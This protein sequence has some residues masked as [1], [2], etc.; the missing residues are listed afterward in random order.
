MMKI[1]KR[2]VFASEHYNPL[3]IVR[4]LGENGI[5]V[6]A[7]V[8][9]SSKKITSKSKF[10]SKLHFVD[11]ID[12]GY[13][14]LLSK[15]GNE[16]LKPLV[17]T[18]DDQ[19]TN[20]LDAH[21]NELSDRFYFYNAGRAHRISEFQNKDNILKLAKRHGLQYLET[22]AVDT[23]EVPDGLQYPIITKAII[24]TIDNWKD[25]MFICHNEE[26]LLKAYK[27]IRSPRVLLQRY[28]EKKN[29]LCLE[30]VSVNKGDS[31]LISIASTYNYLLKD[32]YSPYMT[33]KNLHNERV[34]TSLKNMFKEIQFEG[35]F[36][37]EFLIDQD[38][39]LYFLE[40]N[41]R[42]STWSYAS[43]IAGMPLPIIWADGMLS[44]RGVELAYRKIEKPFT[45]MVEFTDYVE[46]VKRQGYPFFK[47]L[48]DFRNAE[49]KY[50]LG[51][52]DVMP[53]IACILSIF[54]SKVKRIF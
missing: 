7:I 25:D 12:E 35:I 10:I 6:I 11:S 32:S 44:S 38:D 4:S 19:I 51:K 48:R 34:E 42:N 53:F 15:Y 17:Y 37:V 3:G 33:V 46:R 54:K 14:L 21:Y 20:F 31:V 27:K 29:E 22:F 28:I 50:Y 2:I 39:Q 13:Q 9:K 5:P 41:F 24:S 23:G 43:T 8:L 16:E 47:W 26:E 18:A 40:I 45:A 36:E 1:N 30:G 52:N 49:C